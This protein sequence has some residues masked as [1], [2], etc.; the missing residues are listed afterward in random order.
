MSLL[1]AYV[2]RFADARAAAARARTVFGGFGAQFAWAESALL[3][4]QAELI[5]GDTVAA[6]GYLRE[7]FNAFHAM[8]ERGYLGTISGV[9]A[10]ALYAQGR[11]GDAQHMTE[12]AEALAAGDDFDAQARWRAARAKLLARRGDYPTALTLAE[13]AVALS[14]PTSWAVLQAEMLMAKAEVNRLA[15]ASAQAE[16]S[17]REAL[18]IYQYRHAAALASRAHAALADLTSRQESAEPNNK[19]AHM[20]Q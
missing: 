19:S 1:Y 12:Q 8:G 20:P 4:G 18:R 10:E 13:D 2:G 15:G 16:S 14:A 17:L 6:E 11:L 9:L 3:A 7:G 5:A